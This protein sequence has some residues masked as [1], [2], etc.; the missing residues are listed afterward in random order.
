MWKKVIPLLLVAFLS[1]CSLLEVQLD[2]KTTPLTEQEL[3][4]RVHTRDYAQYFFSEVETT[5]DTLEAQLDP[6]DTVN[7]SYLL[8]WKIHAEQGM[9]RAAFQSSPT[10]SLIDSWVFTEQMKNY[11][12]SLDEMDAFDIKLATASSQKL[13]DNINE[14]AAS[15]FSDEEYQASKKFVQN[16]AQQHAFDDISFVRT[17]AYR[18]WIKETNL[19]EASLNMGTMPEAMGDVSDRVSI[20]SEQ[21]PKII[22]WKAQ[23]IALNSDLHGEDL[24]ATLRSLRASS[25]SFQDFVNNNPEYMQDLAKQMA[26]QLQPLVDDIDKKTDVKLDKLSSERQALEI[27]VARERKELAVILSEQREALTQDINKTSENIVNLVMDKLIDLIKSTILYFVL[28]IVAIFFAPL[29]LGYMLGKRSKQK[30]V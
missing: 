1:G 28:F 24:Q 14:L 5:S 9:Q 18:D 4:M 19:T 15:V 17:P 21:A 6:N 23:L 27:M 12:S 20:S 26:V 22:G 2:S 29:G 11:F 13:S 10:A 30:S 16:F 3:K 7:L 25:E 8:L